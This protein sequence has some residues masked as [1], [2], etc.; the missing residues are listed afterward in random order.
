ML[1]KDTLGLASSAV[2][3][4]DE[5]RSGRGPPEVGADV[6][7]VAF[8]ALS[9]PARSALRGAGGGGGG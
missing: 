1:P 7:L 5:L 3:G 9:P 6:K 4:R 8:A 2:E